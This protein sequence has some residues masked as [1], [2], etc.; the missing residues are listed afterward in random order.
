M[1]DQR[2]GLGIP[3]QS[4][5]SLNVTGAGRKVAIPRLQKP[6]VRSGFGKEQVAGK[7]TKN[8]V[9]HACE[10]CRQ[11][12]TKVRECAGPDVEPL[13]KFLLYVCPV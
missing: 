12:K 9:S 4:D 13:T 10:P 6:E 3:S 8:R 1:A 5:L 7:D 2:N 11:R